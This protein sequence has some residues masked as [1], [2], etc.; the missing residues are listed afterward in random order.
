MGQ[1][2]GDRSSK[3]KAFFSLNHRKSKSRSR[4]GT[5]GTPSSTPSG[6]STLPVP[7]PSVDAVLDIET[8]RSILWKEAY[9]GLRRENEPLVQGYE[10]VLQDET[11]IPSHIDGLPD[12]LTWVAKAQQR[13]VQNRQWQFQWFGHPQPVRDAIERILSI[14]QK[15]SSLLSVG[16]NQAPPYVSIPWCA[17]AALIPLMMN[18]FK[19][20]KGCI[21]GL[22]RIAKLTFSYQMAEQTF[23]A[24]DGTRDA[25]KKSVIDLYK[26]ILE[27]QALA[28]RYFGRSTLQRLGVNIGAAS[29]AWSDMPSLISSLDTDT[30]RSLQFLGQ[31]TEIAKLAD[32]CQLLERQEKEI[33]KL[34]QGI[35]ARGDEIAQVTRWV[36]AVSAELDHHDIR[37]KLGEA[38][39]SS[40]GWLLDHPL[41][42]AWKGWVEAD[43]R[44]LWLKGGV[45]SG[46]S[47]LVSILIED[48]LRSPDGLVAFFYCSRKSDK[49]RKFSSSSFLF[50]LSFCLV[51]VGK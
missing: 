33:N 37:Q 49:N 46:K 35:R 5:P 45:G 13:R 50:F 28:V 17:V 24:S 26:K 21:A 27:Y 23:L 12:Q 19:E 16:M 36:S 43:S 6:S 41:V 10:A 15:S 34:I 7:R 32:I 20:H 39:F 44:C 8:Q 47:S 4:A 51:T 38:H 1:K 40:G 48:L 22:E 18:E 31:R 25:Y 3:L 2:D 9:E 42:Q 29:T 30:R 11:D 14:T